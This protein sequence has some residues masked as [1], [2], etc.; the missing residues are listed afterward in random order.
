MKRSMKCIET[1]RPIRSSHNL[2]NTPFSCYFADQG[3]LMLTVIEHTGSKPSSWY[4]VLAVVLCSQLVKIISTGLGW[5][6]NCHTRVQSSLFAVFWGRW[7]KKTVSV[8][9]QQCMYDP[10]P[11]VC[12]WPSAQTLLQSSPVRL[13]RAGPFQCTQQLEGCQVTSCSTWN[14]GWIFHF[15]ICKQPENLVDN[16]VRCLGF[17]S[18][19]LTLAPIEI[20]HFQNPHTIE[21]I[22]HSPSVTL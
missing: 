20:L 2:R 10:H 4:R 22:S 21:S 14:T 15:L 19:L 9:S 16:L 17:Q 1:M 6:G 7:N 13:S 18:L 3:P 11:P 12:P 8:Q 5:Q